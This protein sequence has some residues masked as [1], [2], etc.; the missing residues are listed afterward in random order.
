MKLEMDVSL[1][2]T[3]GCGQAHRWKRIGGAW[4]GVIG[5]DVVRIEQIDDGLDFRGA[6][7]RA[8]E[9]YFRVEDDL[10]AIYE[11]ISAK[12][13]YVAEL[14]RRCPGL[15][16]LRQPAWEC[17]GTYILATNANVKRI[18]A[19]VDSVC[20]EF[21]RDI[22]CGWHAFPSAKDILDGYSRIGVCK[23]GYR[24]DRLAMLAER[25]ESGDL[26]PEG[27]KD[28]DYGGCRTELLKVVGVG[29]KV[30]DCISLFAYGHQQAFP[31][32]ARI[33]KVLDAEYSQ[34]G[35]Y[36]KLSSFGMER[37]GRYAG[38][39]QE[40]LYHSDTVMSC[41]QVHFG[42]SEPNSMR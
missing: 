34:K 31:V 26:D 18:A 11:D 36:A 16:I 35:N 22:G 3:L 17:I 8:V 13:P 20:N 5:D 4:E 27:L 40:L 33:E 6:P 32:D 7:S 14:A 12:D 2:P 39:A 25:V 37:F 21:G 15:R 23:L 9:D 28:L 1:D 19:M 30:A 42:G 41:S 38:Y 10:P 24:E 29:P